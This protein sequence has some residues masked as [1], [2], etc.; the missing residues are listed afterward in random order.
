[1]YQSYAVHSLEVLFGLWGGGVSAVNSSGQ[2]GFTTAQLDYG[3]GRRAIWQVCQRMVW[4]FHLAVYGTN[5]IDEASVTF[6]DRYTIF[7]ETAARMAQFA[8]QRSS[9]VPVHETLEIVRLLLAV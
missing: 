8:Q 1:D 9:P 5:G 4:Q 2:T 6:A 7:R 3:D